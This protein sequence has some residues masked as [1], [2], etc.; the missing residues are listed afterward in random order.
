MRAEGTEQELGRIIDGQ[1]IA[2][3]IRDE[4]AVEV[5]ALAE[6]GIVPGLAVILVGDDP[7]SAVYVAS[8]ERACREA[9]MH[10]VTIKLPAETTQ[11]ALLEHVHALNAD[12]AIHG[13]LVQMPLPRHIQSDAIIRAID[14][15]KD[16]DGFHPINVGKLLIG[17]RD[18]FAPCTPAGVQEL[19]ARC[20]VE[21]AGKECV[22]VGRSNIVGKPMMS[23][24]V[25][26]ARWANATVTVCHRHTKD[27]AAHT[28]RADI[29][30]AATG[31]PGLL[32][33]DMVKRGVVVI[34]VGINR[35]ED[36]AHAKGYRI[37]G[38]VDFES[39]RPVASWITPVPKGV[40][41]MTI[42]MLMKNTVRAATLIA[43]ARGETCSFAGRGIA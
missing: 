22:I 33:A 42:A 37:V 7:A 13:I 19:L 25:Q 3:S 31:R 5:A 18:G 2:R 23:L 15:R 43:A 35:V 24:L 28:R 34:D 36:A 1:A 4:L 9:G 12:P 20:G 17:E 11:Q 32:T 16:V 26:D 6:G 14:P 10:G 21:T 8:K 27:L 38:D 40:G 41:P 39:V 30:I 29:V